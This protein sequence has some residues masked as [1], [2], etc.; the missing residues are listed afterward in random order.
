MLYGTVREVLTQC[1]RMEEIGIHVPRIV[2]LHQELTRR[3][4]VRCAAP[5]NMEEAEKMA[6]EAMG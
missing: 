6:R 4:L 2:S 3:G 5:I 1:E